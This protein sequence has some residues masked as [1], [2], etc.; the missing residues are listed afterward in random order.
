MLRLKGF[1]VGKC[2]FCPNAYRQPI[3]Q[4][5]AWQ[6]HNT[7]RPSLSPTV[8]DRRDLVL[9]CPP[10]HPTPSPQTHAQHQQPGYLRP[11]LPAS[12]PEQPEPWSDIRRDFNDKIMSGGYSWCLVVLSVEGLVLL[13]GGE[14][15]GKPNL[16]PPCT[17]MLCRFNTTPRHSHHAGV[18][19]WQSPNY[20]SWFAGNTSPPAILAEMLMAA[21]NMVGFSW[22]SCPVG[23]ELEM[24]R[25]CAFF[26]RSLLRLSTPLKSGTDACVGCAISH[27]DMNSC[28]CR[29]CCCCA[30]DDG[31][32]GQAVW[33]A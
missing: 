13:T 23:T 14:N 10:P 21:L 11:L 1:G 19:H 4:R 33:P 30:G 31:L 24:V 7:C 3:R 28:V 16:F 12:A 32:A 8:A 18:T 5:D 22:Q 15:E 9:A 29:H 2:W 6:Q 26:L 17:H 25:A 27:L 20:F